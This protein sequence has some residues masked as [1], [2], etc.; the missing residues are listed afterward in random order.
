MTI[1]MEPFDVYI[2]YD[3]REDAAYKVAASSMRRHS[4]IP[5]VQ[6]KL[7]IEPLIES[8]FY[9]RE[10]EL[11]EINGKQTK[12]DKIDGL[13]FSTDFSFTRFWVPFLQRYTG[14]ALFVDCDFLFRRSLAELW[15]M[16]DPSKAV[17]VVKHDHR[18]V[19]KEKMDG[20]P[21]TRYW[22]KNWSSL[23]LWN[24]EH[25][26]N[27]KLGPDYL[28]SATG[29]DL[30]TFDH[31]DNGLIGEIP[32]RWNHLVGEPDQDL[33]PAAIH[34]TKGGPWFKEYQNVPYAH[35]WLREY[36]RAGYCGY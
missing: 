21:Q 11:R 26:A 18:P 31:L 10:F 33:D 27:R 24:C 17:M 1:L 22:R 16:R 3:R 32:K 9:K 5:L 2:G 14:W 30:H 28:N 20:V 23:M 19:E 25:P 7:A 29:Y 35:E 13:P 15:L 36:K 34:F 6:H 8:G 4:T 12:V